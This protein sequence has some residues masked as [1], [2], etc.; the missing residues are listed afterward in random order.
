MK[1]SVALVL[2]LLDSLA[3]GQ[4]AAWRVPDTVLQAARSIEREGSTPGRPRHTG[5]TL[6]LGSAPKDVL[7]LQKIFVFV[8]SSVWTSRPMTASYF[9]P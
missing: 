9:I 7:Q 3:W 5:H 8:W 2:L 1:Q 4:E 6:V